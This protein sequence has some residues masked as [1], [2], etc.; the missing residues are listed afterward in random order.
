MT[1]QSKIKGIEDEGIHYTTPSKE[2]GH[3]FRMSIGW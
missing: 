2:Q 3:L 1:L